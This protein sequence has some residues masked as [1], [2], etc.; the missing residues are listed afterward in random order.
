MTT[1]PKA[2]S[3]IKTNVGLPNQ[4][5]TQTPESE[6]TITNPTAT[7]TPEPIKTPAQL[8]KESLESMVAWVKQAPHGLYLFNLV[9]EELMANTPNNTDNPTTKML[10]IA[11]VQ[12]NASVLPDDKRANLFDVICNYFHR[13]TRALSTIAKDAEN[14][15]HFD[16]WLATSVI[17]DDWRDWFSTPEGNIL[18]DWFIVLH[19][20]DKKFLSDLDS[21]TTP[22]TGYYLPLRDFLTRITLIESW[23]AISPRNA[24]QITGTP[25]AKTE[26]NAKT[27]PAIKR[28]T[29]PQTAP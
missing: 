10:G 23:F 21:I 17:T 12:G 8:R 24:H 27:Q 5:N 1:P 6:T 18:D 3:D 20:V 11:N 25:P 13:S 29:Q 14:N 7:P 28:P 15:K 4:P 22:S 9:T 2:E 16:S 26:S 19:S